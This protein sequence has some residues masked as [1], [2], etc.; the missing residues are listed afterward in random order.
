VGVV[1]YRRSARLGAAVVCVGLLGAAC[2]SSPAAVKKATTTTAAAVHPAVTPKK[3]KKLKY[4]TG[5]YTNGGSVTGNTG[6]PITL[7]GGGTVPGV[8]SNGT[9]TTTTAAGATAPAVTSLT[10]P[11]YVVTKTGRIRKRHVTP[12]I[13]KFRPLSSP[14]GGTVII[15]GKRLQHATAVTFDGLKGVI[16]ANTSTKIRVVVPA[17]ATN[18]PISVVT[19]NGYATVPGFVI[20]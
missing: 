6:S 13:A 4:I 9:S 3:P 18:G 15:S 8:D 11:K 19:A 20:T 12:V 7:P 10:Q 2:S 16:S 5:T 1:T 17:G 14:V